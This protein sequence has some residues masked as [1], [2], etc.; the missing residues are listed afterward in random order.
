MNKEEYIKLVR[1]TE[2][3]KDR[4]AEVTGIF[5]C[6][7]N[8]V[9]ARAISVAD[10]VDFFDEERRALSYKEIV[11]ASELLGI[12]AVERGIIPVVDSYDCTYIV[13]QVNEGKWAKYNTVDKEVFKERDSLEEIV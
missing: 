7:L 6:K 5:G 11:G 4:E 9:L 12:D 1:N 8:D 10:K 3:D 13:Y 2:I